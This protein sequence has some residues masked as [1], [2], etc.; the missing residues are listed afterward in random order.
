MYDKRNTC[1]KRKSTALIITTAVTLLVRVFYNQSERQ[2]SDI[3]MP[4]LHILSSPTSI[5]LKEMFPS[6]NNRYATL[7]SIEE[8][9][10]ILGYIKSVYMSNKL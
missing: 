9:K 3:G 6:I 2:A 10:I 5:V 8:R 1:K 4:K 7:W